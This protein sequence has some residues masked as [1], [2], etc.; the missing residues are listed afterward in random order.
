MAYLVMV[1]YSF[2]IAV[3]WC[4]F[5]SREQKLRTRGTQ[6]GQRHQSRLFFA[7]EEHFL[8]PNIAQPRV[9]HAHCPNTSCPSGPFINIEQTKK[10][11]FSQFDIKN[12]KRS[13]RVKV[14]SLAIKKQGMEI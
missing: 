8:Q 10:D 11:V 6:Q 2:S 13:A 7:L 1:P 14:V 4:Q 12:L 3:C 9:G 5:D